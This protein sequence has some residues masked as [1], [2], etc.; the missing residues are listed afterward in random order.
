MT[1]DEETWEEKVQKHTMQLP[2]IAT[3][4]AKDNEM[5]IFEIISKIS[6]VKIPQW[7]LQ[8]NV[9]HSEFYSSKNIKILAKYIKC[10]K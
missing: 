7:K 5:K 4:A 3:G 6:K 1:T 9:L 8:V 2:L 10:Q